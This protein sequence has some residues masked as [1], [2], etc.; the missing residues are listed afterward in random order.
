MSVTPLDCASL[1]IATP[2][3]PSSGVTISIFAPRLMSA[4]ASFSWVA[5]LPCALSIRNWACVYPAS[6]KASVRYGASKSTQRVDDVVSGRITPTCRELDPLVANFVS[7][8]NGDI[9]DSTLV[10]KELMLS[11]EG[12]V[13]E[14]LPDEPD[15][16]PDDPQA[17]AVRLTT[18][19]KP[20]K[21][22]AR[23]L[24]MAWP[25]ARER[26]PPS[27]LLISIPHTPFARGHL[28]S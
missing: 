27:L 23:R 21:P 10:E 15:D 9:T 19:A 18:A 3:G 20:T 24:Y 25:C 7:A 2:V 14:P 22:T 4:V 5:S 17:A 13:L 26:R 8:L 1:A 16:P 28:M 12:T 6:A 11:P